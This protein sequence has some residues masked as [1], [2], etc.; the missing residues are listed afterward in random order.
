MEPRGCNRWQSAT[1]LLDG[2]GRVWFSRNGG[3]RWQQRGQLGAR[4]AALLAIGSET[5]FAATHEGEI[6]LSS[7]GGVSWTTRSRP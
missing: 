6:K 3:R 7:D 4:P 1:Y 5:L 2:G